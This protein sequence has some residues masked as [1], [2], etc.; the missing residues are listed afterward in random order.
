VSFGRSVVG[1][2]VGVLEVVL[3]DVPDEVALARSDGSRLVSP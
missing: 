3:D 1:L 2:L